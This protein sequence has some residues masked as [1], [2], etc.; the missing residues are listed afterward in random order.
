[1]EAVQL[2]QRKPVQRRTLTLQAC[3]LSSFSATQRACGHIS[4]VRLGKAK[5]A[6]GTQATHQPIP[7]AA[8]PHLHCSKHAQ[9]CVRSWPELGPVHQCTAQDQGA[10]CGSV[11]DAQAT[12]A[13]SPGLLQ[14]LV[15]CSSCHVHSSRLRRGCLWATQFGWANA[16]P[17]H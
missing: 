14:C 2:S 13:Q 9:G 1:M 11:T 12:V 3:P 15:Q 10:C 7:S 4:S 8:A 16:Q 17:H 5:F 6:R